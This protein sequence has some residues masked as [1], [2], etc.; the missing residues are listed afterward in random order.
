MLLT[1]EEKSA[2]WRTKIKANTELHEA[3]LEKE[4]KRYENRKATGKLK[5]DDELGGRDQRAIRRK[6]RK[7][8]QACR[9]R[10]RTI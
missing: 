3:Y 9:Q 5:L 7:Q 4:K 1:S 8:Q 2:I 10:K 6:W